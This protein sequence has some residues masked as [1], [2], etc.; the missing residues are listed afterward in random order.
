MDSPDSQRFIDGKSMYGGYSSHVL[1]PN[2]KYLIDYTGVLPEGTGCVYMCSGLTAYS[3]LKK[4]GTPPRGG[5]DVLICAGMGG[6]ISTLGFSTANLHSI[7]VLRGHRVSST[8]HNLN[9]T[10]L[11]QYLGQL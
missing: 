9:F 4:V 7:A 5:S 2:Y 8:A 1:V 3:A 10:G 6:P 11:T